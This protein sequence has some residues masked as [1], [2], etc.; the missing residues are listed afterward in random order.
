[1]GLATGIGIGIQFSRG[2][3]GWTQQYKELYA[4]LDVKP[5]LAVA[6]AQNDFIAY[7]LGANSDSRNVWAKLA[8]IIPYF[9]GMPSAEDA[10][11]WWNDPTRKGILSVTAP[12][13]VVGDGF[14]GNGS[15]SYIDT[16]F[17]P[18]ADGGLLYTQNNASTG[19]WFLNQRES[20]NA[21]YSGIK[22]AGNGI[23]INPWFDA[24]RLS[25][26]MNG[27]YVGITNPA[28]S[29]ALFTLIRDSGST[30]NVYV[31]RTLLTTPRSKVSVSLYNTTVFNL[32]ANNGSGLVSSGTYM[33]DT[34]GLFYAGSLL[35]DTDMKVMC[36]AIDNLKFAMVES[37][38]PDFDYPADG[39]VI[40]E[41]IWTI[42][43]PQPASV[44]F[45]Q[46]NALIMQSLGVSSTAGAN[47]ISAT[48]NINYGIFAGSL[49]D[50]YK[51]TQYRSLTYSLGASNFFAIQRY[52]NLDQNLYFRIYNGSSYVY[53][54]DTGEYEFLIYKIKYTPTHALYFYKWS[55]D[56]WVLVGS[57]TASITAGLVTRISMTSTG[58]LATETHLRDIYITKKDFNTMIP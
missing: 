10:L 41:A 50:L 56:A 51:A 29:N 7:L 28:H 49:I 55:N 3:G 11:I 46:N 27:D 1:M 24:T 15:S 52:S 40:N 43:N 19:F 9:A 2:G 53:S 37:D 5:S 54:L 8:C 45:I 58:Y 38:I 32:A 48:L 44:N 26:G 57:Y 31:D 20:Y 35:D 4:T 39:N 36:D 47:V 22:S 33:T 30:C 21:G 42:T 23:Y 25:C 12:S 13:Y 18:S 34:I 6:N 16:T 17:N 14:T